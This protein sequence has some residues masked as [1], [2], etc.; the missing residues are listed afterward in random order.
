MHTR[1]VWIFACFL[2][3]TA[4][5]TAVAD[6]GMWIP[7]EIDVYGPGQ[8]AIIAWNGEQEVLILST[9]VYAYPQL[10][11]NLSRRQFVVSDRHIHQENVWIIALLDP[12]ERIPTIGAWALEPFNEN[13]F[14]ENIWVLR[15][16]G[17][18]SDEETWVLKS[19][20]EYPLPDNTRV[21]VR[22]RETPQEVQAISTSLGAILQHELL[23]PIRREDLYLLIPLDEPLVN[24]G[25]WQ[26]NPLNE[27]LLHGSIWVPE[28]IPLPSMPEEVKEGDRES[29]AQIQRLLIEHA[30][31][32]LG[33]PTAGEKGG[34]EG[35]EVV[36]HERIGAH[37]VR[38]VRVTSA[39]EF[40]T[41]AEN[42][43][44]NENIEYG[45]PPER[46]GAIVD[47]YLQRGMSYFVFDLIE[48]GLSPHSIDPLI[49]RFQSDFLYYPLEVSSLASGTTNITL[50]T[51][52]R[53]G[54]NE[55]RASESGLEVRLEFEL[56]EN[57][58]QSIGSEIAELFNGSAFLTVLTYEGL[59]GNLKGDLMLSA[60][61]GGA[62][63]SLAAAWAAAV[64]LVLLVIF[65]LIY[66]L[67]PYYKT[68]PPS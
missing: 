47:T 67:S 45:A 41:W 24:V 40:V 58:L 3:L 5:P 38:V 48:V 32:T 33:P 43:L 55:Q 52:T 57:E 12:I 22:T 16:I 63:Q 49:Y 51:L 64:V 35:V 18:Y 1:Y 39:S 60:A 46:L 29:F 53:D 65:A 56:S 7:P 62:D 13:L 54:I 14:R 19:F 59:L 25:W 15:P 44:D 10:L 34:A 21:G 23:P 50:F 11:Q 28:F 37:D 26:L 17:E 4:L 42:L 66:K 9:D 6:K 31:E 27:H 68:G 30:L 36:F 61:A 20:D 2:I 8:K